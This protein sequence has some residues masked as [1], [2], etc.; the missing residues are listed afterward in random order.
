[1]DRVFSHGPSRVIGIRDALV[2][3][4]IMFKS[5][6]LS[7]QLTFLLSLAEA[8]TF[9]PKQALKNSQAFPRFRP[10]YFWVL[11]VFSPTFWLGKVSN[12]AIV[13][14]TAL[15]TRLFLLGVFQYSL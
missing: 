7:N 12:L 8:V 3:G 14:I 9:K 4:K 6:E 11:A 15:S 5:M 13:K 1:M 2:K 10:W